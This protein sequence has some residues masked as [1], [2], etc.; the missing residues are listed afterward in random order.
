MDGEF[1]AAS[2]PPQRIDDGTFIFTSYSGM[3]AYIMSKLCV[4]VLQVQWFWRMRER[5]RLKLGRE[6]F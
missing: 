4:L 1:P 5:S 2:C 3:G 6:A